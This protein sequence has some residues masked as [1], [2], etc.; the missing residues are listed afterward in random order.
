LTGGQIRSLIESLSDAE[1][2]TPDRF[3][4]TRKSTLG[5]YFVSATSSHYVW[6][7]TRIARWRRREAI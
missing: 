3:A 7:R 2:F 1:L 4:W 6:A 5:T